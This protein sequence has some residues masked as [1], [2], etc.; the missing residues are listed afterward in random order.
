MTPLGKPPMKP[1]GAMLVAYPILSL[2]R[3][4]VELQKPFSTKS[5]NHLPLDEI[6]ARIEA[7]LLAL[8]AQSNA[9][10]ESISNSDGPA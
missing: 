6:T 4:G 1:F 2:D 5:L 10:T 8:L 3:I 9:A 7:D